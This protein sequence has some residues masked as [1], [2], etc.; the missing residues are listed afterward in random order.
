[1]TY[2]RA[3]VVGPPRGLNFLAS[4]IFYKF[5]QRFVVLGH[6]SEITHNVKL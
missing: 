2:L 1:M 3:A 5:V 4:M 6:V